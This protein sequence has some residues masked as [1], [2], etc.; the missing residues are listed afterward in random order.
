E[1]SSES[2]SFITTLFLLK[3]R[4]GICSSGVIHGKAE[5]C[6]KKV[7]LLRKRFESSKTLRSIRS[8]DPSRAH[9]RLPTDSATDRPEGESVAHRL[10]EPDQ[11]AR[12]RRG[13]PALHDRYRPI[14]DRM[15]GH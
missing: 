8:S 12:S 4:I 2:S 13:D 3:Y 7:D 1:R 10:L 14:E 5:I 11:A 15:A 9:C 6:S